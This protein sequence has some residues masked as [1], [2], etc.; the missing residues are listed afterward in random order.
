MGTQEV[1]LECAGEKSAVNGSDPVCSFIHNIHI[2]HIIRPKSSGRVTHDL[3]KLQTK[4]INHST[5]HYINR[6]ELQSDQPIPVPLLRVLSL[7]PSA[8]IVTIAGRCAP[9]LATTSRV[10]PAATVLSCAATR[11]T[12]KRFVSP[13]PSTKPFKRRPAAQIASI[14]KIQ[15]IW[16]CALCGVMQLCLL[17]LLWPYEP[18]RAAELAIALY[19]GAVVT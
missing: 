8:C 4:A 7:P 9:H 15:P 19:A 12:Q 2:S 5:H 14:Y 11:N 1:E 13:E 17:A 6:R 16:V 3:H 18:E 10:T